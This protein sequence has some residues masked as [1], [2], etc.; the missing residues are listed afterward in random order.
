[1]EPMTRDTDSRWT[2]IAGLLAGAAALAVL[3]LAGAGDLAAQH[4]P[5]VQPARTYAI[6]GATIHTMSGQTIEGG[7]VLVRDGLIVEVGPDVSVPGDATVIDASGKHVYPGMMDAF[8]RLGLTEIGAVDVSNDMSEITQWNPHLTAATAVHPASEHIP[9]TRA[10]GITHALSA[11]GSGGGFFGG[12]GSGGIPGRAA[13]IHLDGWTV[14]EMAID[15]S[16]AMVIQWPVIRTRSFNFQRFEWEEKPFTEAKEEFDEKVHELEDWFEA[17]AH[18]R[19]AV[20]RG[21]PS[22]FD[23]NLKLEHLAKTLGGELPVIA[24]ADEKRSIESALEFAERHDLRLIIAGG[25]DARE[26][27][28]ELAERGIPVILGPIQ[29][30]PD[31]EDDPYDQTF[32]LPGELHEA[33]V[34]IAFATFNSSDSRTLPYEAANAVPFGLPREEAMKAIT[35][36]A[37]EILGVADRLGSVEQG[38]VGNL[39]VTDGDP[40]E[41]QTRI[42]YVFIDGMPV[43]PS[44][45]HLELYEEYRE[46]PQRLEAATPGGGGS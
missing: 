3:P 42:E 25:D 31:D 10:N 17:A 6:Q 34:K 24:V 21:D 2:W 13:L 35:R 15:P 12:G 41:I 39:I 45:K 20:E 18:Y 29:S 37:A 36:N 7:T 43:D 5:R 38:K 16:A 8:S 46:R 44:N 14:E 26:L 33:G 23:R 27:K 32:T 19:Q 4:D 28:E 9:V 30:M 11:P 1:M 22:R 40:L